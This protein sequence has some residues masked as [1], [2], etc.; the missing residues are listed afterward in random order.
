MGRKSEKRGWENMG[1]GEKGNGKV[2]MDSGGNVQY[3]LME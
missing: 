3:N 1:D 2:R